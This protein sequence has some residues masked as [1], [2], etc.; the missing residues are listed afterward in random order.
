MSE[1]DKHN[2]RHYLKQLRDHTFLS[3]ESVDYNHA[4]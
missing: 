4:A 2:E 1:A 3:I